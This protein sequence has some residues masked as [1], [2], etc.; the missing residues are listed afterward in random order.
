MD[1][2]FDLDKNSSEQL[3]LQLR[4]NILEAIHN[5]SLVPG[6]QMPS[7]AELCRRMDISRMTVRR[8]LDQLVRE[9]W[10]YTVPGKGTFVSQK[11]RIDQGMQRLMGWT[12]EI[13]LK[14]LEPSTQLIGVRVITPPAL[15]V[16]VLEL[17]VSDLVYEIVRVRSANQ[18]ALVVEKAYLSFERFPG[19]ERYIREEHSLYHILVNRFQTFLV[20]AYQ[21]IEAGAADKNT[22]RLLNVPTGEPLLITERISYDTLDRPVEFVQASIRSGLMRF[23]A[24]LNTDA[25]PGQVALREV[26]SKLRDVTG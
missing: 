14:G 11:L 7:I 18:I 17:M 16:D 8:A 1:L 3:Y 25:S 2:S 23:V 9:R 6:Q 24:E 26:S 22:A 5:E 19:L 12:D 10:L 21:S 20:R 15:V 13:R 4:R